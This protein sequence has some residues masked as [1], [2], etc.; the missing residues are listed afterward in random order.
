MS[1]WTVATAKARFSEVIDR[2][3]V[4]GPQTIMRRGRKAAVIISAEEW[5]RR[6]RRDGNLAEFFQKSPLR[7]SG[8]EVERVKGGL[9]DVDL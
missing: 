8:L 7:R 2:A 3:A 5:E 4:E 6:N 9:R 1:S